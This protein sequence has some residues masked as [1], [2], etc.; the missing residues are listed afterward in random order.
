MRLLVT[1][2]LLVGLAACQEEAVQQAAVGIE[3]PGAVA[4]VPA[5]Q[6]EKDRICKIC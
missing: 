2:M 1:C 3:V 6:N 5:N 4:A